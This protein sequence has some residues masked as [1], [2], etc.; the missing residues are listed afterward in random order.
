M[1]K[2]LTVLLCCLLVFTSVPMSAL[3]EG[4]GS[5]AYASGDYTEGEAIVCMDA[6]AAGLYRRSAGPELLAKAEVLMPVGSSEADAVSPQTY[7]LRSSFAQNQVLALVRDENRTTAELIAELE[8]YDQVVF[9]EPNYKVVEY[10]D[11]EALKERVEDALTLSESEAGDITVPEAEPEKAQPT[12]ET[13]VEETLP[14]A[15]EVPT[16]AESAE[17]PARKITAKMVS[18]DVYKMTDYQWGFDNKGQFGGQTGFDMNDSRWKKANSARAAAADPVVVA[19]VDSGVDSDNPDL[20]DKMWTNNVGLPGGKHGINLAGGNEADTSD[21]DNGH[22][23]H[24]AGIIGAEWNDIG[25]SGIAQDTEI[26]AIKRPN[27]AAGIMKCFNYMVEACEKGVNLKVSSNSWG[28]A[29]LSQS[30]NRAVATLGE[31]GAISVFA[32]GN[33]DVDIDGTSFMAASLAGNPYAVVVNATD[34]QGR[35]SGFSCYGQRLTDVM[36]PGSQIL[37]TYHQYQSTKDG[38][39][40]AEQYFAEFDSERLF[41]DNFENADNYWKFDN[42]ERVSS[43]SFYDGKGCLQTTVSADGSTIKSEPLDLSDLVKGA[44]ANKPLYFS[45]RAAVL[46]DATVDAAAMQAFVQTINEDGTKQMTS[47]GGQASGTFGGWAAF[48]GELPQNT[49]YEHFTIEIKLMTGK[50]NAHHGSMS[51]ERQPGTVVLDSFGIG[52]DAQPYTYMD[53]T[54]MA[55]PAAAG[56]ASLMADDHP[57]AS[58]ANLAARLIG[59][60]DRDEAF[61]DL[62]VSGGQVDL[63]AS[64]DPYPVVTGAV[65]DGNRV[66]V[67]GYFF[68]E[69]PVVTLGGEK[70]EIQNIQSERDEK[71]ILTVDKPEGFEGGLTQVVVGNGEKTGQD[72]FALG[73]RTELT[74]Y[75]QTNLPLPEDA[76]FYN[77]DGGQIVGYDGQLYY[78]PTGNIM[79]GTTTDVIWRYDPERQS[80]STVELPAPVTSVAGTTWNGKLLINGADLNADINYYALYDGNTWQ[81]LEYSEEAYR[82]LGQV[83]LPGMA[84]DGSRV[85]L[86]GGVTMGENGAEDA[87]TVYELNVENGTLSDTGVTLQNGRIRPQVACQS[88]QYLVSGGFALGWNIGTVQAVER[89]GSDGSTH[90]IEQPG[91]VQ[92]QL[93]GF[94]GAAVKDGYLL[95]GPINEAGSADTYTLGLGGAALGTYGKRA[96]DT[97]LIAPASAAYRGHFY[98]LAGSNTSPSHR[99]FSATAVSTADQP[100]DKTSGGGKIDPAGDGGTAAKANSVHT[101]IVSQPQYAAIACLV[102]LSLLLGG[103]VV[104]K[105]R[106]S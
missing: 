70:A 34:S 57:D 63:N 52:A 41:Y 97:A 60:V 2:K 95:A 64:A 35:R 105:K 32:S 6:P 69:N 21:D 28:I 92:E 49:D 90:I 53:G 10:N 50:V 71:I 96:D 88:G 19:V 55:C 17:K 22:G 14:T 4:G 83:M 12:V 89:I 87:K 104:C 15:E 91:V 101:G 61:T 93:Y 51:L 65:E 26:M 73:V 31:A 46:D 56:A 58:A 37:S 48:S 76:S 7:G 23:T 20:S 5:E 25:V 47:F 77:M 99:V 100:G 24:C 9:A 68:G 78:L 30:L 59:S 33:S 67:E 43:E 42:T 40:S 11:A 80:W 29:G 18:K 81:E 85:L 13:A 3:A 27:D 54:S 39:E 79:S 8:S 94:A 103:C 66:T 82:A 45:A 86:F 16:A 72:R 44:E 106:L 36:A 38:K 62:C 75:D 1:R 102:L 98:V 84:N 74:Y